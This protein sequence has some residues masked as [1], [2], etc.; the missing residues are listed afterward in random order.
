MGLKPNFQLP[1]QS[2]CSFCQTTQKPWTYINMKEINKKKHK[3]MEIFYGITFAL[4][5]TNDSTTTKKNSIIYDGKLVS[6]SR[7]ST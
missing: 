7:C 1:H 5:F 4:F 6:K 3:E 2:F